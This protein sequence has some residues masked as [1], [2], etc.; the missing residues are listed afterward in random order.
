MR[1]ALKLVAQGV[2][3]VIVFWAVERALNQPT[4]MW[5][6]MLLLFI[7]Y[8]AVTAGVGAAYERLVPQRPE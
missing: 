5:D 1:H 8:V 6:E 4:L 2:A 3:F 7:A